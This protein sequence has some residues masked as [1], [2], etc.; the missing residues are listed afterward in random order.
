MQYLASM[1]RLTFLN[2]VKSALSSALSDG[3]GPRIDAADNSGTKDEHSTSLA[4]PPSYIPLT[5]ATQVVSPPRLAHS[6][7]SKALP[8]DG[9]P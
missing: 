9:V 4:Q 8:D 2:V 1:E 7:T 3:D 6:A 5:H